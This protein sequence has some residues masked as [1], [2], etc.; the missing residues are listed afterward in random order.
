MSVG[1]VPLCE[2]FLADFCP[3]IGFTMTETRDASSPSLNMNEDEP[4]FRVSN[5]TFNDGT[6]VDTSNADII[7]LVGPNNSGKTRTLQEMD[8]AF[9]QPR[10]DAG[11]LFALSDIAVQRTFSG[12]Q[13]VHWLMRHRPIVKTQSNEGY[14]VLSFFDGNINN[15][16]FPLSRVSMEWESGRGGPW[17]AQLGMHLVRPLF[18]GDRL[19]QQFS[20]QRLNLETPLSHPVHLLA[21]EEPL[22]EA[23][24]DA[25]AKAFRM[26][27]IIDGFGNAIRIRVDQHLT[28]ND[29]LSTT[30]NGLANPDVA[31]RMVSVPLIETQSDGVRSFAGILLTLLTGQFPLVLIDEPE[32]FLH[33]P[34][35]KLLGQYLAQWHRRGQVF[36]STHSL[37]VVLG[38]IEKDP[39]RVLIVRLTR[40][41]GITSPHVLPPASLTEISRDPLLHYSRALDGLFHHAVILCEAERDCTFYSASLDEANKRSELSFSPGDILFVP[42][43][44]KDGFPGMVKALKAVSIPVVVVPDIDLLND[45]SKVRALVE[46]FGGDWNSIESSYN[47]ATEAFRRPRQEVTNAQILNAVKSAL[48]PKLAEKY[49]HETKEAIMATMRLAP[50]PWE[51]LKRYGIDAFKGQAR[52]EV[53]KM[54]DQLRKLGIVLVEKGELENLAPSVV[55]RKGKHW[56]NEALGK[57]AFR[58]EP[59]QTHIARVIDAVEGLLKQN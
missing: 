13:L 39:E 6:Q 28:Q 4:P 33:P 5:L 51:E 56:I 29:F 17:M 8:F 22:L 2:A 14:A 16:Q 26:N 12:Q 44:G 53:T 10:I 31:R 41:T 38:L 18:C 25:F 9:K 42:A 58:E 34:Q 19:R 11:S 50:S 48:T 32:A 43:G 57:Q 49:D 30:S 54:I 40:E 21:S 59:A 55:S 15:Q 36:V 46:A 24:R 1:S 7:V 3:K 20:A 23:F 45:K 52:Q 27:V 47:I 35:A 37:D